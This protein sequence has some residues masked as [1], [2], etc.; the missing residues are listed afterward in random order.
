MAT[1]LKGIIGGGLTFTASPATQNKY[2]FTVTAQY[3]EDSSSDN[4]GKLTL[5]FCGLGTALDTD[6]NNIKIGGITPQEI[7][8]FKII[9]LY[10]SGFTYLDFSTGISNSNSGLILEANRKCILHI[11][12]KDYRLTYDTAGDGSIYT[13]AGENAEIGIKDKERIKVTC[14]LL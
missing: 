5:W 10:D 2:T 1:T 4:S 11:K 7:D 8:G 6:N 14:I 3:H 13:D 9:T 12:G